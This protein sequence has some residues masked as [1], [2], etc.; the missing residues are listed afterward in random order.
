MKKTSLLSVFTAAALC[1]VLFASC[2]GGG[3]SSLPA[4]TEKSTNASLTASPTDQPPV[5]TDDPATQPSADPTS[6]SG[7]TGSTQ[8]TGA[9]SQQSPQPTS[10]TRTPPAGTGGD[11]VAALAKT[12]V[13]TP[14]L[15]GAAGP[16][17]FDNSGLIYYCMKQNGMSAPRKT[18]DIAKAGVEAAK[19]DLRPGD[20]V[21]FWNDTPGVPQ[22][23]GIYIGDQQFVASNN[24]EKPTSIHNMSYVY[25]TQRYVT[26]RRFS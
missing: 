20:V 18:G 24:E 9:P 23:A 16:D 11:A 3:A 13:D 15:Y 5:S 26:A 17:A 21:F 7:E 6:G 25:F 1:C 12:L 8:P 19:E 2:T 4:S 14:Y 10:P 22:F